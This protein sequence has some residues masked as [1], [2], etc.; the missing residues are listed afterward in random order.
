MIPYNY[1]WFN[2]AVLSETHT[3]T[4]NKL[5]KQ[6]EAAPSERTAEELKT[7]RHKRFAPL[8]GKF[9]VECLLVAAPGGGIGEG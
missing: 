3:D 2:G 5:T 8:G 1:R 9:L 6:I 7:Q 4:Y